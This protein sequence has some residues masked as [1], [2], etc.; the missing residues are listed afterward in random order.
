[1]STL[2]PLTY[3][4]KR[5]SRRIIHGAALAGAFVG[6]GLAQLPASDNL[7]LVPIEIL[8][9]IGLGH[10]FGLRLRHSYRTALLVGTAAT[11]IGRGVSE[12]LIGWIPVLGNVVDALT[13]LAVIE[14]LGWIVAKEFDRTAAAERLSD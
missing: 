9:V 12:F 11:M 5:K 7:I 13:A 6:A 3:T 8:M 10:A 2:R 1:V 14:V 4:Q